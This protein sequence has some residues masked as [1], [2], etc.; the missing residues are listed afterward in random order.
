M[1]ISTEKTTENLMA[2]HMKKTEQVISSVL[3]EKASKQHEDGTKTVVHSQGSEIHQEDKK[4]SKEHPT[5]DMGYQDIMLIIRKEI[6][7]VISEDVTPLLKSIHGSIQEGDKHIAMPT[8]MTDSIQPG[9]DVDDLK[10]QVCSAVM[11]EILPLL[12]SLEKAGKEQAQEQAQ[13]ASAP[14]TKKA[15]SL[16]ELSQEMNNK[17]NQ[18]IAQRRDRIMSLIG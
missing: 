8:A 18:K 10:K 3:T 9:I 11:D 13:A 16:E 14:S 7:H 6:R 17:I 5:A 1:N 2:E 12:E 4:E 15:T